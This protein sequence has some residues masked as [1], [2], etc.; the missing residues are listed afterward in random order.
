MMSL[1]TLGEMT[2]GFGMTIKSK[3][4]FIRTV[5]AQIC[6]YHSQHTVPGWIIYEIRD[7]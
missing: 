7:C 1:V 4:S 5:H 2:G 3:V 6:S